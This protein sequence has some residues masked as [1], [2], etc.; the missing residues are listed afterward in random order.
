MDDVRMNLQLSKAKTTPQVFHITA[1][2]QNRSKN[3]RHLMGF[4]APFLVPFIKSG[5]NRL[6][7]LEIASVVPLASSSGAIQRMN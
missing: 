7:K 1:R 2:G 5:R 3:I 4:P 6:L